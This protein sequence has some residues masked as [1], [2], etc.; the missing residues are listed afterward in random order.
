MG[1]TGPHFSSGCVARVWV[2]P[3]R[4]RGMAVGGGVADAAV[5]AV[6]Y[7]LWRA[8]ARKPA[9]ATPRS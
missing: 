9:S 2:N 8:R 7:R 6:Q 4:G 1:K 5:P 3:Q